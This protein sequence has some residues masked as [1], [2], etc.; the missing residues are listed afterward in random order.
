MS[1]IVST[2]L[3]CGGARG[4]VRI[5]VL[6]GAGMSAESGISTFRDSGGLWEQYKVEDV[7]TPEGWARDPE[8]VTEF[9]N[10]RRQQMLD[11]QPCLGHKLLAEL[12]RFHDVQII[13][14]NVDDLHE[15][16]GSTKVIHLHGEL[17]KVTSS[18]APNAPSQIITLT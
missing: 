8:L 16:A 4:R 10:L 9:Y 11:A 7:A 17:M 3:P 13:T 18:E 6:T 12:E 2:P 14:Q 5:L 15:R 1:D